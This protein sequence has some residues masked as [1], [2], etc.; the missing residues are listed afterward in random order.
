MTR[1]LKMQIAAAIAI[2]LLLVVWGFNMPMKSVW[3]LVSGLLIGYVL[4]RSRFGFAGGVKRP[5]MTGDTAL[6]E[7]L[8]FMFVITA[9]VVAVIQ[10]RAADG[11]AVLASMAKDGLKAIPGTDSVKPLDIGVLVGGFLF[12]GGMIL[13]GGCASG[14][15]TDLGEGA[16][17]SLI[18]FVFYI[19]G[20]PIGHW[21]RHVYN[22]S[23]NKII[24]Y[25]L[26]LPDKLGY[27]GSVVLI[28][29]L[30][31]IL[32]YIVKTYSYKR[33]KAGTFIKPGYEEIEKP[34][35]YDNAPFFS[36]ETYHRMFIQRWS[37]M[38]GGLILAI[39]FI[40][41]L[42]QTGKMWGVTS[43]FTTLAVAVFSR[44]GIDFEAIGGFSKE[45]EQASNLFAHNGTIRNIGLVLGALISF[46]LAGRFK[47][48]F[49]FDFKDGALYALGG[50]IM[51]VGARFARGCNVGALYSAITTFSIHGWGF[52]VFMT[53]GG[54]VFLKFFEGKCGIIPKRKL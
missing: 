7:A 21:L 24:S 36:Y 34:L 48:D 3:Y 26:Y 11:G 13:A 54:I 43:S 31:L 50:F 2:I 6:N 18:A 49:D 53:I 51:G 22:N 10:W 47:I 28:A 40:F 9:V 42:V 44:I 8:F 30:F 35:D 38:R 15:L 39:L 17:R 14:T 12:G 20:A 23:D 19:V 5:Y 4:T 37:F 27:I 16:V 46:L 25:T 32:Y 45:I 52:L 29:V 1:T 33:K 41:V